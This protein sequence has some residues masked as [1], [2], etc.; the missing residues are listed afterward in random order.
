MMR[1]RLMTYLVAAFAIGSLGVKEFVYYATESLLRSNF[2]DV[3]AGH[4][5]GGAGQI[6]K[7]QSAGD[8]APEAGKSTRR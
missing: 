7:A 3:A 5:P 2:S 8:L 1:A 6:G 4:V